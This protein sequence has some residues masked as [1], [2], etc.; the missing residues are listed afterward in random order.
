MVERGQGGH[1]VNVA[2][3]AAYVP[4]KQMAAYNTA[5]AGV[6][7]L[8]ECLRAELADSGI[9]VSAIC[10][11]VIQT[12]ITT[13]TR[14]GGRDAAEQQRL[15]ETATRVFAA[16]GYPAERVAEAILRAVLRD[17]AVVPVAPE[18]HALR[19]LARLSPGALRRLAR[20]DVL[21]A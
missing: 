5:K 12:P 16:R 9:G 21:P 1:I 11:G 17:R 3:M 15:R 14:F 20:S 13:T 2:S 4:S 18:A 10:P 7:M 8:S 6:L 19:L